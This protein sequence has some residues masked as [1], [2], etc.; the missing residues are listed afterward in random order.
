M[1]KYIIIG[2]LLLVGC[3]DT[4]ELQRERQDKFDIDMGRISEKLPKGCSI[5]GVI[6]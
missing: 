2:F 1:K 3:S 6:Q 5:G 4:Q